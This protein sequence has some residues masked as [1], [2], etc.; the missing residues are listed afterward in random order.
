MVKTRPTSM[1]REQEVDLITGGCGYVGTNLARALLAEG[2]K[3][4]LFDLQKPLEDI[5]DENIAFIQGDIRNLSEVNKAVNDV[6][7]VYHLAS[8]GMSGREQ[9]NKKLIEEV[10]V[11][12]TENVIKAC[13][14][15][16]VEHLVYTSTYNVVFGGQVI[17]NG[18]ETLPYLPM[19]KHSDHY[20]K[21]KSIA[22]Q[23]VLYR[24]GAILENGLKLHT[25]AL[26]LAGVY[27]PGEQRHL[28]RI[29]NYIERGYFSM[30][31]GAD[32]T[33][34]DFLHVDNLV[35][36]HVLAGKGL[37]SQRDHI[38]QGQAYFISD[39]K[40]VN[41][42]LFFKPMVEGLG[43]TYPKLRVPLGLVYFVAFLTELIHR[44]LGKFYNFQPLL[45][46]TEVYKTGVTHYFNMAKAK[47]HLGYEPTVQNDLSKV[48]EH[49]KGQ[50]R[51]KPP[52]KK[53]SKLM[54]FVVDI[55][56]AFLFASILISFLPRVS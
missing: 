40:P 32:K 12:G 35:Q 14:Q 29:M 42:F 50:G 13:I 49:F 56:L 44:V 37:T 47:Q 5:N 9:L 20:S 17:E 34:V 53:Q 18:D 6:T 52:K 23:S 27:G 28:P 41:N 25:C 16:N 30:I 45:T 55:I 46:R 48:I 8:Y 38:A 4:V 43:Y 51:E 7:T 10:N 2:H 3:V 15:H 33:L 19:D 31:Y 24:N 11:L 22:E 1:F 54:R 26:R 39:D 36:A 21:T